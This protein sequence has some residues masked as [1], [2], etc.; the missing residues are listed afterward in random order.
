M[1]KEETIKKIQENMDKIKNFGV[2]RIGIF[3]SVVKGKVKE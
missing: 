2:K 1:E 3:G